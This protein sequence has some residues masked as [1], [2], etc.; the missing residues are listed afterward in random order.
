MSS[1]LKKISKTEQKRAVIK[2]VKNKINRA[3][4]AIQVNNGLLELYIEE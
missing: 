1:I 2:R 4:E 3:C